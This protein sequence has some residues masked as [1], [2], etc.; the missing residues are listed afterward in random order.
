[1][2]FPC[3]PSIGRLGATVPRG[4]GDDGRCESHWPL[5][6]P[7]S[8]TT[9]DDCAETSAGMSSEGSDDQELDVSGYGGVGPCTAMVRNLAYKSTGETVMRALDALGFEGRYET[10]YVPG[11]PVRKTNLGYGFVNFFALDDLRAFHR[12]CNNRP[13]DGAPASRSC[14]ISVS[15]TQGIKGPRPAKEKRTAPTTAEQPTAWPV[16]PCAP[17]ALVSGA[18]CA[19]RRGS[20]PGPMAF[21]E[22]PVLEGRG[23]SGALAALW[24]DAAFRGSAPRAHPREPLR[25][26]WRVDDRRRSDRHWAHDRPR[27]DRQERGHDQAVA[28]LPEPPLLSTLVPRAT[29]SAHDCLLHAICSVAD[30]VRAPKGEAPPLQ[31]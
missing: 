30:G 2:A 11:N 17:G 9:F 18:P 26:L 10:V 24:P 23:G 25:G 3:A 12:L 22:P 1:M 19:P 13:F 6:R 29:P 31:A 14:S 8:D 4:P 21:R 27:S 7:L 5:G 15:S 20:P 16:G 28:G